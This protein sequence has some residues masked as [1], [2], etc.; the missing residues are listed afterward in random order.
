[1]LKFRAKAVEIVANNAIKRNAPISRSFL[2]RKGRKK[3]SPSNLKVPEEKEDAVPNNL[4][5][6]KYKFIT[7][8]SLR[9]NKQNEA[10]LF[11]TIYTHPLSTVFAGKKSDN[12]GCSNE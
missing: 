6:L 4:L 12:F 1:M 11:H 8:V 9:A 5:I 3:K 2:K 7:L 10:Y